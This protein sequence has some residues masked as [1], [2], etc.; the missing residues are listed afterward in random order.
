[1]DTRAAGLIASG[2]FSFVVD[3]LF[4]TGNAAFNIYRAQFRCANPAVEK[5]SVEKQNP[6]RQ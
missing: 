6:E 3:A 2:P 5:D 4:K 1:M